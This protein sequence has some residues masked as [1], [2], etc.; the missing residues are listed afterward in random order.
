M[1]IQTIKHQ[2]LTVNGSQSIFFIDTLA[3]TLWSQVKLLKRAT[4]E[5]ND[6][7][8]RL[9]MSIKDLEFLR[10][11]IVFEETECYSCVVHM[12]NLATMQTKYV[13]LFNDRACWVEVQD[14]LVGCSLVMSLFVI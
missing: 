10:A 9:E 12:P 2:D 7:Q 14:Q 6:L 3:V 5:R 4:R 1:I 13:Y 8:T 11:F